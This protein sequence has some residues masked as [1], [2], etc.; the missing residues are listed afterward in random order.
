MKALYFIL[1]LLLASCGHNRLRYVSSKLYESKSIP[2]AEKAVVD[3]QTINYTNFND[4]SLVASD[5]S[6]FNTVFQ[7][8][9]IDD[10]IPIV[11]LQ[12]ETINKK[13]NNEEKLLKNTFKNYPSAMNLVEENPD[14]KKYHWSSISS[15]SLIGLG[16]LSYLAILVYFIFTGSIAMTTFY[17]VFIYLFAISFG[18]AAIIGLIAFFIYYRKKGKTYNKFKGKKLALPAIIL[19]WILVVVAL[20]FLILGISLA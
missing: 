11:Q 2:N 17:L 10:K 12:K 1:A 13:N 3:N 14:D 15:I 7:S 18:A 20:G 19:G 9:N 16:F 4:A 8:D 5:S 6:E